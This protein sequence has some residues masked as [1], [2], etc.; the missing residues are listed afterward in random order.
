MKPHLE[1]RNRAIKRRYWELRDQKLGME[2]A[3]EKIQAEF[4]HDRLAFE[5]VK[6]IIWRPSYS[7]KKRG[8]VR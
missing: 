6:Q 7:S 3:I 5:T 2:A 4:P 1:E 8:L